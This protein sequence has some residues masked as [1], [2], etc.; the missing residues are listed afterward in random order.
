MASPKCSLVVS[1]RFGVFAK[2]PGVGE[3]ARSLR[4]IG[5]LMLEII[6]N[7][8][9]QAGIGD[10]VRRKSRLRKITARDL[11]LALGAGLDGF[12]AAP[13]RKV[14]RLVI[15]D[16]EMQERVMFDSAPVAAE[17]RVGGNEIDGA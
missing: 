3:F 16:L 1:G 7:R 11:V 14:D 10:V 6:G 9:A 8:A 17:Q 13:D 15:A 5:A 2:G 4:H 12:Q